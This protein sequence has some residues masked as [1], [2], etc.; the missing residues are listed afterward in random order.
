MANKLTFNPKQVSKRLLSALPDRGRD[1][2]TKRFGLD[3]NDRFTL[4][5]I[6]KEY[7]ITRE[8]VRQIENAALA[9]IRKADTYEKQAETFEELRNAINAL[10]AVVS[11]DELLSALAKDD[12]TKNHILFFLVLADPFTKE[13]EDGAFKQRWITDAEIASRVQSA[14]K[15][16][17]SGITRDALI[18]ENELVSTFL[19][20]L[21][22][23]AEDY[24]TEDVARRWLS[25]SKEI[26]RNPLGE[27]G[28]ADSPSVSASS[29]KDYAFLIIRREGNPMH[30]SEVARAIEETFGKKAHTATCH[31]ELIKD[32]RFVLVGRGLY[33]LKDWGYV[34]GVVQDVIKE[35]L[36]KHGPLTRDEI[37]DFV[38]KE[39][40]VKPNTIIVNLQNPKKFTRDAKGRYSV[41]R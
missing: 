4:D 2:L 5:A 23:I 24:R 9:A 28:Y 27:W 18:P 30:F 35:I 40:Y 31:N 15:K 33:A 29:I 13:K 22:D 34:P 32:D 3:D 6:G 25:L 1:V 8:R 39:R 19:D 20:M 41:A 7:G 10:G 38:M 12:T 36:K 17:T 26:G 11:E 37:I 14:L 16:L 21:E